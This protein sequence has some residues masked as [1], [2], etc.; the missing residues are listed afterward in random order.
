MPFHQYIAKGL[1]EDLMPFV[2]S[3][4]KLSQGALVESAYN[5]NKIDGKL[6]TIFPSFTIFTMYGSPDVLGFTPGW[7]MDEFI[8]TIESN[9]AAT[10]P[11]G[12]GLTRNDWLK[13][14]VSANMNEYVDW[15]T[16]DVNFNAG[17]FARFLEFMTIFPEELDYNLLMTENRTSLITRGEQILAAM[18][19]NRFDSIREGHVLFDGDIVFKGYPVVDRNGSFLMRGGL[20]MSSSSEHKD[21]VWQFM[22]TILL[23]DWQRQNVFWGFPS[24]SVVFNEVLIEAKTPDIYIDENG[25]EVE[26]SKGTWWV[27]DNALEIYAMTDD[28][29]ETVLALMNTVKNFMSKDN[30]L[31]AIIEEGAADFFAGRST[32][33]AAAAQIQS[34][35]AIYVAEQ[36]K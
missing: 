28:E 3:D 30:A 25:N 36:R 29:I 5:A 21:A 20:A 31:L 23:E 27:D 10:S 14:L 35:A 17:G 24:N 7:N 8:S 19:V 15:N 26:M 11:L 6:Y 2:N 18:I 33:D 12:I 1:L 9:P 34:R 13:E 4:P 32:A 16:G 22:R